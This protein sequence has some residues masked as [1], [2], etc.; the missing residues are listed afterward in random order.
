[1]YAKRAMMGFS[2]ALIGCY[3]W[4]ENHS[5]D[6]IRRSKECVINVPTADLAAVVV[7]IGNTSGRDID[8]FEEFGLTAV[9]ATRVRAPLIAECYASLECRVENT[10]L[11]KG[12]SFFVFRV[13]KAHAPAAPKYPR[14]LHYRGGGVFMVAGKS[15]SL[16][17]KFKPQNL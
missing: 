13:V 15:I 10:R 9:R 16:R 7:G 8:K 5:F 4:P 12:Y 2:P 6:M 1:M 11:L 14:T 17:R 3:I